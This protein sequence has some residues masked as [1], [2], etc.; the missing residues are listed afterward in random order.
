VPAQKQPGF[1]IAWKTMTYRSV[2]LAILAVVAAFG[3]FMHFAFPA[4]SAKVEG[5]AELK[6]KEYLDK[7]FGNPKPQVVMSTQAHFTNLDGTVT[8]RKANTSVF[9]RASY[10]MPLERGDVV[11][12]E[13]EGMAKVVF[14]GIDRSHRQRQGDFHQWRR[15]GGEERQGRPEHPG[16]AYRL[17]AGGGHGGL[18]HDRGIGQR[19]AGGEQPARRQA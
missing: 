10:E 9:V 4:T 8:V 14:A 17:I 11:K 3:V 13:A 1:H 18:A 6:F 16:A 7:W 12:T 2:A 19:H 15:G 5:K